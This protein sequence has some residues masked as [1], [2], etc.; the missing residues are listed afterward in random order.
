MYRKRL[1]E[2]I[3]GPDGLLADRE[4][5]KPYWDIGTEIIDRYK[6]RDEYDE[7]RTAL[8]VQRRVFLLRHPKLAVALRLIAL[9]RAALRSRDPETDR[10][11]LKWGYVSAARAL[12]NVAMMLR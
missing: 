9:R 6:L 11:L 5:L 10:L 7:Y 3:G 8:P 4:K 1:P 12:E 2:V